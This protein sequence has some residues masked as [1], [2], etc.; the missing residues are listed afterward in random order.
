MPRTDRVAGDAHLLRAVVS[1]CT[2]VATSHSSAAQARWGESMPH[3]SD[4][5][6]YTENPETSEG[7]LRRACAILGLDDAGP[8]NA[9]RDRLR[10]HR[11]GHDAARPVACLNPG[12]LA[13]KP[14]RPGPQL[15]RPALNEYAP[16]F[17]DE[18]TLVHDSSDFALLL[19]DQADITRALAVTFGEANAGLRYAP[20]KWSVRQT[21]GRL[22][23]CERVLSYRLLRALRADDVTL[24]GFDHVAY[25][26]VGGFEERS[27]AGVLDEFAAVREATV[28]LVQSAPAHAFDFRLSGGTG[29]ITGRALAYLMAGHERHHQGLLRTRYLGASACSTR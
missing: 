10:V 8:G 12:A 15:T 7:D 1:G 6:R 29:S 14:L 16:V 18:I 17:A 3:L 27:L 9:L 23:D 20:D 4:A 2:I 24:P 25:V 19:R 21:I 28:A 13:S 22:A 11:Q 5:V 26:E